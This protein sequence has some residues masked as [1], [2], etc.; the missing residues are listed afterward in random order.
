MLMPVRLGILD[1]VI[2]DGVIA[3]TSAVVGRDTSGAF[4]DPLAGW[5]I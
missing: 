3:V 1:G 4:V 2:P 5:K